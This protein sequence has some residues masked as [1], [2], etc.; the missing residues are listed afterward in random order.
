MRGRTRHQFCG[1][2]PK[3][4][5]SVPGHVRRR[6]HLVD[7]TRIQVLHLRDGTTLVGRITAVDE[8]GIGATVLAYAFLSTP[9]KAPMLPPRRSA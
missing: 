9:D 2:S 3:S 8:R 4:T 7:S 6:L 1:P 5:D